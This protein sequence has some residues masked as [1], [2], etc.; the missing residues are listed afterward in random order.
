M[1]NEEN[2]EVTKNINQGNILEHMK[3]SYGIEFFN[4]EL[5]PTELE[6]QGYRKMSLVEVQYVEPLFQFAPQLIVDKINRGVVKNA[7]KAATEN[8]YK[9]LLD[10]S[11][12]L[13]T[14]KGT[15]DLFIGTGLDNATNKVKGQARWIKKDT[16]LSV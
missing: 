7:F 4:N 2:T 1:D 11:M 16:M 6:S 12:H 14:I 9:C 3:D 15:T 10:P 5:L 8:S 13:A